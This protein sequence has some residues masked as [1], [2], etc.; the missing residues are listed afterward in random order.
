MF[1]CSILSHNQLLFL[2]LSDTIMKEEFLYSQPQTSPGLLT[3]QLYLSFFPI[4]RQESM[5]SNLQLYTCE[6][7]TVPVG[8]F[9]GVGMDTITKTSKT[10][11]QVLEPRT[12][13]SLELGPLPPTLIP[14]ALTKQAQVQRLTLTLFSYG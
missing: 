2:V 12:T 6:N 7:N 11:Q 10:A 5:W 3:C 8:L 14:N 1:T 13:L 9:N 4:P